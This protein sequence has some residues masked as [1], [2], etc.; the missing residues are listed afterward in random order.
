MKFEEWIL[1]DWYQIIVA[2]M[3]V[4][5]QISYMMIKET[6]GFNG[7]LSCVQGKSKIYFYVQENLLLVK[8]EAKTLFLTPLYFELEFLLITKVV[9]IFL[10]FLT[11]TYSF[12]S[13]THSSIYDPRSE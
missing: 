2:M 12:Q 13:D 6:F 3:F 7:I 11:H 1:Y 9:Y 5:V 4:K 8:S 10:S